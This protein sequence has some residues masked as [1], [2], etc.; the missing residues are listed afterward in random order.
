M[1]PITAPGQPIACTL[2]ADG[3]D[4]AERLGAWRAVL[5]QATGREETGE[6]VAL[7]FAHDVAR[8]A[9]LARLLAAEY[10]CCSFASYHLTIDAAGV[11]MEVRT[12]PEARGALSAVFGGGGS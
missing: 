8:T 11:R 12:R 6:G 7:T 2:E 5:A 4:M 10:A 3:G 1:N 9:E